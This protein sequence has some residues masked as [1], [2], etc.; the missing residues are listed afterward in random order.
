M[1]S[2]VINVVF[3]IDKNRN[4]KLVT[5]ENNSTITFFLVNNTNKSLMALQKFSDNNLKTYCL[6][7]SRPIQK[8]VSGHNGK[9]TIWKTS[10]NVPH[11]HFQVNK[12]DKLLDNFRIASDSTGVMFATS[13]NDKIIRIRAFHDGKLLCK[14]PVS[15]SISS[16]G[17]I[18]DDNYLIATSVE[19]Y[20]YFYKLNQE[21]IQNLKKNNDLIN[22]TEEKKIINNK[23]KLLQKF[24]ENDASLS[25]NEEVKN[26]FDKFQRSEETTF[27]DLKKLNGFVKEGKKKHQD[28]NEENK[29]N[30]PKEVIELKEEKPNNNDDQENENNDNEN[31]DL[32]NDNNIFLLNKSKIFKKN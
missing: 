14:I 22:S 5:A 16:L 2:P 11:K 4:L 6:N 29:I 23:L 26:L 28:I 3:C 21:L 10:S 7:Y 19:G 25:K 12:G 15:E 13:N 1:S 8:I 32:Q 31:K 27:E 17:F 24:M 9:I 20:L 18:L 30:K